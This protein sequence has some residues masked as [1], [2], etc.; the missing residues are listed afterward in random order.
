MFIL[1]LMQN[2]PCFSTI[3]LKASGLAVN[4]RCLR[5]GIIVE[6]NS[7]AHAT[8]QLIKDH[9]I[10]DKPAQFHL[11]FPYLRIQVLSTRSRT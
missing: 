9:A 10:G 6:W 5:D 11:I 3:N 8:D 1:N 7:L 2:L 4:L